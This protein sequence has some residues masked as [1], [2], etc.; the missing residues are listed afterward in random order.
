MN[1]V[2]HELSMLPGVI[3]SCI[4]SNNNILASNLPASFSKSMTMDAANNTRRMIQMAKVKG[5]A[6]A[7]MSI[8]YDKFTVLAVPVDDISLLL[9]LCGRESNISLVAT[10]ASM[11]TPEIEKKLSQPQH[12]EVDT[13]EPLTLE[14]PEYINSKTSKA[15]KE[16]KTALFETV[17][18][19]A[20]MIYKD[21]YLSWTKNNPADIG[22]IFELLSCISKELDNDVFFAE[23]KDKIISLL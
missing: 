5:L 1:T 17:G 2:L 6:P 23:F 19:I 20:D 9:V 12:E 3:G 8:R 16:I 11:L 18:P 14:K 7:N 10:T 15:L 13:P 4:N 21:C 22:R